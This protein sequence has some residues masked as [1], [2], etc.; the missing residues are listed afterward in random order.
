[1]PRSKSLPPPVAVSV[2]EI[3]PI[4]LQVCLTTPRWRGERGERLTECSV[5]L[6]SHLAWEWQSRTP[7]PD[8]NAAPDPNPDLVLDP[9]PNLETTEVERATQRAEEAEAAAETANAELA[10]VKVALAAEEA[11]NLFST[12]RGSPSCTGGC[13]H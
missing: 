6:V 10:D 3:S 8:P 5:A 1:M 13:L 9:A 12:L 2:A 7:A 4:R 11:A